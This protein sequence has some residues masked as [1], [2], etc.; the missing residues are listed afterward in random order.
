MTEGEVLQT[1]AT[2]TGPVT[3][4]LVLGFV[5]IRDRLGKLAGLESEVRQLAARLRALETLVGIALGNAAAPKKDAT[6]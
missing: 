4:V 2:T 3:T 1:I 6:A 5:W